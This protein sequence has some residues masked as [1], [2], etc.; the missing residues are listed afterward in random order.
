MIILV[1]APLAISAP[2][3]D[4]HGYTF[5][6]SRLVIVVVYITQ[7]VKQRWLYSGVRRR[8]RPLGNGKLVQTGETMADSE[9]R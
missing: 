9:G 5:P 3:H 2:H 1:K 6:F 4:S 8:A 7:E